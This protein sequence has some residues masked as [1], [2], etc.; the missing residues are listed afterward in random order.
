MDPFLLLKSF[1]YYF[2]NIKKQK[3]TGLVC[4]LKLK[5]KE[6]QQI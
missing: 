6:K 2:I 1:K 3:E 4:A 5:K